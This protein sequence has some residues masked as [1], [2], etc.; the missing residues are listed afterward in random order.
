MK[1]RLHDQKAGIAILSALFITS[2]LEVVFRV[3]CLRQSLLTTTNAG[4]PLATAI[5]A[6]M[7]LIFTLKGKH[8]IC[9]LCY[10]KMT[11]DEDKHTEYFFSI[12]QFIKTDALLFF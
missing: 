5:F 12:S 4:Q 11:I 1:K 8:R 6:A 9:Y 3:G 7:L 2:L 10:G